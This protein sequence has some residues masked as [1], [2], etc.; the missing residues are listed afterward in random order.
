MSSVS[1][2]NTEKRFEIS[3]FGLPLSWRENFFCLMPAAVSGL[4]QIPLGATIIGEGWLII[5]ALIGFVW[6][7]V[8]FQKHRYKLVEPLVF[9]DNEIIVPGCLFEDKKVKQF[10]QTDLDKIVSRFYINKG[11]EHNSSITFHFK[12]ANEIYISW[13]T[14]DLDI[15]NAYLKE[16]NISY[17]RV[18]SK[19]LERFVIGLLIFVLV[20]TA[21]FIGFVFY[22]R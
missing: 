4:L 5:P 15:L 8:F 3:R 6:L 10:L 16:K 7:R 19:I 18:K 11:R 1:N 12:A 21:T 22:F 17:V 14:I 2:D 9:T 13:L 20:I